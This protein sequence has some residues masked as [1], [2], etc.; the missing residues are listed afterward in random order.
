MPKSSTIFVCSNCQ[1]KSP[2][3]QGKCPNCGQWNSFEEQRQ[4]T[5]NSKYQILKSGQPVNLSSI[6]V[7]QRQKIKTGIG[8]F[9]EVVGGGIVPGSLIL[10]GGDPGI[11]KSTLALQLSMQIQSDV[12]YVS[13]EES[14]SQIKLRAN[15]INKNHELNVLAETDLESVLGSIENQKPELVIIDSIQT[16]YSESASGVAGGVAQVTN[17]VQQIMRLAKQNHISF[18]L[19]GHVTKEGY[20]AG[21]KTL[22]HMVDTV[23]YLEGERFAAFRILRCVKNRFGTTNEVG[24]FEMAGVGLVEVKNPSQL[25]LGEES[26]KASGNIITSIVEGSRALLLEIQALTSVTN[27]GYPKRTTAGFDSNRLQLLTAILSKRANLNLSNQD[28]YINVVGGIKIEEPGADLSVALAIVSSLKD[29]VIQDTVVVGELGLS[30][31]VRFV[32]NLEKRIKEAE[33]LGFKKIICP[34]NKLESKFKIQVAQ[35]KTLEEAI[36]QL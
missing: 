19:I 20:L 22:E 15:R 11:G 3:W 4:T 21:P 34:K 16:M 6:D 18:I 24:V 26:I 5:L 23:L 14:A 27:F 33:K 13:G 12:L 9:D 2:R 7:G 25:F 17:A 29:I 35:V 28:I 1:F 32:P 10:L 30:G 8:E 36:K 31:E